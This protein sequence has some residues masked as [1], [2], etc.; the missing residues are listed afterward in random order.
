[1][2]GQ[3]GTKQKEL[4]QKVIWDDAK[5]IGRGEYLTFK[6]KLM[7]DGYEMDGTKSL[8]QFQFKCSEW[9]GVDKRGKW[10]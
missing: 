3:D 6:F 8:E 5:G 4:H 9:M 7:R 1:M 2:D 10:F